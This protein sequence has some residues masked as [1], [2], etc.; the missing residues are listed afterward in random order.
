MSEKRSLLLVFLA[1]CIT[2]SAFAYYNATKKAETLAITNFAEIIAADNST[3]KTFSWQSDTKQTYSVE[4]KTEKSKTYEA[5]VDL[6]TIPAFKKDEKERFAYYTY[7][8]DLEPNS[9]Y[10][11]RIISEHETTP[12]KSFTTINKNL[13]TFKVLIFGDSQGGSYKPWGDTVTSAL[14]R[15]K[16]DAFFISMGDIVDNGQ[17]NYHWREWFKYATPL[18]SKMPFAPIVGNH[19][20]YS[21]DWKVA[22]PD[23]Y[24]AL[25]PVPENGPKNQNR[26]AYSFDYGD[27]H[28]V[29][30]NTTAQETAEWYPTLHEDQASW[31]DED[32]KQAQAANKRIIVLMHRNLWLYPFNGPYNS[33]GANYGPLFDKYNVD[34]VF[35]AHL[36]TYSR[37][38]PRRGNRTTEAGTLYISTG[39]S[40]EK[41]WPGGMA[42]PFDEVFHNPVDKT[43]YLTLNVTPTE[44]K[45]TVKN[46]DGTIIDDITLNTQTKKPTEK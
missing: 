13:D 37:T 20:A 2:A 1:V 30:L 24:V 16:D 14:S 15:E 19:E 31:L 43:M 25:F 18:L 28:F 46:I 40:G 41:T 39:R 9:T 6:K 42:K 17:D 33:D 22:K 7:L 8:K 35:T 11:Y 3:E 10:S 4:Y 38:Y 26:L 44:F 12:W 34:L 23:S 32:L 5:N 36:H 21:L 27:V 45:V 29:A